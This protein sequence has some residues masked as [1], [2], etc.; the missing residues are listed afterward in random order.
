MAGRIT[1]VALGPDDGGLLT[2]EAAEQ[3]ES[4]QRLI[5][6]TAR[7]AVAKELAERRALESLDALYE[8]EEDFDALSRL[9]ARRVIEAAQGADV[10]Y[11]V[12]DP[13]SDETV[14]AL[15]QALPE[16]MTLR[17]LSG[18][19]LAGNAASAVL[20]YGVSAEPLHAL[21]ATAASAT[22]VRADA[23]LVLTEIDHR[24]LAAE[25]KLWLAELYD[26]EQTVYFLEDAAVAEPVV[27]PIPLYALDRQA[28]YDHR[29]ALVVPAVSYRAR[30][31][32]D[33]DD[34]LA[35]V[36]ELR[37]PGGCPW[38]R[39]QTH[40]SLSRFL[41][42]EACEAADALGSDDPMK[43]ADELG[44][45]LLQVALNS[46]IGGE[47]RAFTDRDVTSAIVSK[48]IFRHPH[49][50]S[51]EKIESAE[52]AYAVWEQAKAEE[53]GTQSRKARM[54]D[55][56]AGLPALMRAQKV[57]RRGEAIPTAAQ[58]KEA[59][60]ELVAGD[61]PDEALGALLEAA[62]QLAEARGM[63]AENALRQRILRRIEQ[64]SDDPAR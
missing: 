28:R 51:G 36:A 57:L 50:F 60:R 26:D 61:L 38:D 5:L 34:L 62:C 49:V 47:H 4:A 42:E 9:A 14:R 10:C 6:R 7:H 11:A 15:A 17:V 59:L 3:L 30:R 63:D 35:V 22:R 23:T 53:R 18:V 31:R 29:T 40:E 55:V 20:P 32:A 43:M 46:Q 21:S 25:V 58:A 64:E 33:F 13:T 48:M 24:A 56:S 12:P 1:V 39:K 45:V 2:R 37:G 52:A 19:T 41:V 44:D 16:G 54:E 8:T 27:T